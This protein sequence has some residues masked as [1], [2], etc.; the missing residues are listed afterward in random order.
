MRGETA[1]GNPHRHAELSKL[2]QGL[3]DERIAARIRETDRVE[4][5]DVGLGDAH[6]GV[7]LAR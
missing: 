4:H 3:R 1:D 5:A 7:A 2:R 6:W